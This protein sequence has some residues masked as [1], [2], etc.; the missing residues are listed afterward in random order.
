M[1]GWTTTGSWNT[2][3]AYS[4]SPPAS[5]TDS[6][7]GFYNS[8]EYSQLVNVTPINLGTAVSAQLSFYT[9][10]ELEAGYD[11]AQAQVS[12]DGGFTWFALCGKYTT[13]ISTLDNGNPIWTGSKTNWVKEELPLDDYLGQ[14]IQIGFL[15]GSDQGVELDGFYF[16]DVLVESIDTAAI[17]VAEANNAQTLAQN[18]PNPADG[19]TYIPIGNRT[20]AATLEIYNSMGQVVE[21][22]VVPAGAPTL[23]LTTAHLAPGVYFYR[24]TAAGVVSETKRM[25]VV[26]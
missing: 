22:V 11:F 13:N 5:I 15:L 17:G 9:R 10:F 1:T 25:Q 8:N 3:T 24:L 19:Y 18:M 20:D 26:R 6:P 21:T 16:D 2:T 23:R 14:T 7:N 12:N 4:W